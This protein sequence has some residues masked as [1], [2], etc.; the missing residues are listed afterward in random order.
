V[1]E[2]VYNIHGLVE[3]VISPDVRPEIVREIEFQI[4][5]FHGEVSANHPRRP[6][7]VY[8]QPYAAWKAAGESIEGEAVFY[9]CQGVPGAYLRDERGRLAVMREGRDIRIF[10]D[11]ASF[12]INLYIQI[13]VAPRGFTMVHAAAYQSS[14]G[15]VNVLAGAG[16]IGKTAV[17][18]YAVRERKL[19]HLG[20]DLV[21][22]GGS[23][24]CFAFPRAFVLKSYHLEGYADTFRRLRLPRWNLYTLKRFII[25]NAPF[26][27]LVKSTLRRTGL[28]Y[29]IADILRPQPFLASVSPD[30]I[31]G[32]GSVI[33]SGEI[34]RIAYL[35]RVH[36]DSFDLQPLNADTLVNRLFS[37]IHNEWK[38]FLAHLISLGALDVVDVSKYCE[39]VKNTLHA[40]VANRELHRVSIPVGATPE[41]LVKFLDEHGFF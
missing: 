37:V 31:F 3:V 1:S 13:L 15:T 17:L 9:H 7:R 16:G 28:Y 22:L 39:Q 4:G 24:Q 10:S 23:G 36:G 8:V 21:I 6:P 5:S 40:A 29:K 2:R 30:E 34:G 27:G 26:V 25:D 18:G 11:Y 19:R 41:Q 14:R 38:D 32:K 35:D 20:D 33:S 12:L